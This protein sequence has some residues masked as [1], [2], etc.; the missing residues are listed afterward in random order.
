M[1]RICVFA[2]SGAGHRPAYAEA[3]DALGGLL[4]QRGM[5]LVYG[6]GHT[7]LMGVLADATLRAGGEVIGVIPEALR[8]LELAHER[9]PELEVVGSMHA[10]KAR[11]AELADAFI[12]LPGGIGTLE[13]LFEVFTWAQLG[14]HAKPCGL[15]NAAGFYDPLTHFL[16]ETVTEGFLRPEQR[17]LLEVAPDAAGLLEAL[18]NAHPPRAHRW[19]GPDQ[20]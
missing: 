6:G 15:L 18:E 14:L 9:L 4:A 17:A 13:E 19:I 2:G 5:G 10:R 20:T 8:T 3:A 1:E 12:A 16:D 7:G 11:M